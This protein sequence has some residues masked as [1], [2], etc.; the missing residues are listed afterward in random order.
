MIS[1]SKYF[2]KVHQSE[3]EQKNKY[4]F[5]YFVVNKFDT[6]PNII[7]E[8]IAPDKLYPLDTV[9]MVRKIIK[10]HQKVIQFGA[11]SFTSDLPTKEMAGEIYNLHK[12]PTIRV[13]FIKIKPKRIKLV[14]YSKKSMESLIRLIKSLLES[15]LVNLSPPFY[16]DLVE[17]NRYE[18]DPYEEE[19]SLNLFDE[20]L[21]TPYFIARDKVY[22]EE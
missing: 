12:T 3:S 1:E 5:D 14:T 20:F 15:Y 11:T 6:G 21:E 22:C 4:E 2:Q 10:S 16:S 8:E 13:G 17:K 19:P 9:Q 7:D 18:T